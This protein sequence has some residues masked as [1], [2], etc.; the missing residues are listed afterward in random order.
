MSRTAITLKFK[1]CLFLDEPSYW[2]EKFLTDI[3]LPPLMPHEDNSFGW[4]I[5]LDFR[6]LYD[7]TYNPR[8]RWSSKRDNLTSH[9]NFVSLVILA[10]ICK[11]ISS[12][13][14]SGQETIL[15][16]LKTQMFFLPIILHCKYFGRLNISDGFIFRHLSHSG[17]FLPEPAKLIE[18]CHK[19]HGSE[20]QWLW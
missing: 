7:I 10:T 2:A 16:S 6:K 5:V 4:S 9:S 14:L 13:C 19:M 8:I 11:M 15:L 20:M 3:N 1:I 17:I 18:C 12:F